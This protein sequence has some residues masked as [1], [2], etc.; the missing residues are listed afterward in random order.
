MHQA[1]DSHF[2]ERVRASFARQPAML[3]IGASLPVVEAGDTEV[4]LPYWT[5][6][7]QQHGYIHGGV[8]GRIADPA[9]GYAGALS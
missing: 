8:V 6:I 3:L 1:Q 5:E 2:A 4:H 7:T 9:A